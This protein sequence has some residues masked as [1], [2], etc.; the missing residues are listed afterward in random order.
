MI[1]NSIENINLSVRAYNC[2]KRA[3][4]E[5]IEDMAMIDLNSLRNCGKKTIKEINK[6]IEQL[7]E[8]GR[9][10]QEFINENLD[11]YVPDFVDSLNLSVRSKNILKTIGIKNENDLINIDY[12]E[13]KNTRNAGVTSVN[14]IVN[15][16]EKNKSN[17]ETQ[18]A[19]NGNITYSVSVNIIPNFCGDT[20]IDDL[21]MNIVLKEEFKKNNITT[22]LDLLLNKMSF[23]E[24]I[25]PL[26]KAVYDYFYNIAYGPLTLSVS[27]DLSD[28]YVNLPFSMM[29]LKENYYMKI[30]ELIEYII[31][32]FGELELEDKLNSKLFL[33]WINSFDI[34]DKKKY[35]IDKLMLKPKEYKILSLR[36]TRTLEEV[37]KIYGVTR[38]RI[39]QIEAKAIRKINQKYKYIPFKFVDNKKIYYIDEIDEFYSLLLYI[40]TILDEKS[41]IFVKKED[42]SYYLP[43]FYIEKMKLFIHNNIS[44]F[45]NDGFIQIDMNDW[46]N[47]DILNKVV[48]YLNY[49]LNRNILSKRLTKRLQVKY[50]MKYLG[51]PI[52]ISSIEDQKEIIRIVKEKFG[53]E[54]ETGRAME[55]IIGDAGVRVDSGKY[56]ASDNI[57][58]LSIDTLSRI[59]QYVNERKIINTRDLFIVFGDEL[60]EHNLNNETILYRYLKETLSNKLFF[61]GVSA[62]ISSDPNLGSWGDLAIRIMIETHKP[63]N[64]LNFMVEYSLTE[65]VY[66][67][68]PINFDDIIIWSKKEIYLKSLLSISER[69]KNEII[70][71]TIKNQMVKFDEIR[72]IINIADINLLSRNNVKTNDNL[73]NFL[74]NILPER[75]EIDKHNEEVRYKEK[76]QTIIKEVYEETEELTI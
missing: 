39:R 17:L 70:D 58:P 18:A 38:E 53:I 49:N 66:N 41:H 62:V 33:F 59:I 36:G 74:L 19:N 51:R 52:S 76:I 16:I 8:E 27:A 35:F 42:R 43:T 9:Y 20:L 73:Y 65:P 24:S 31:D 32:H 55:A 28:L 23:D 72:K 67:Q 7:V 29:D 47:K 10:T 12:E 61:H 64:K 15:F 11:N 1:D 71:Y 44:Q 75:I 25:M 3:G 45:E 63:I 60:I 30:S 37:G 14:E 21:P 46:E 26:Y 13:L 34:M 22:I 50:A 57:E 4:A 68:L 48:D 40:D 2:L 56:A 5:T 69:I 6:K 54:L